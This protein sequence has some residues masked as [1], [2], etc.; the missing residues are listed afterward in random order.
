MKQFKQIYAF[1]IAAV[2]M[3]VFAMLSYLRLPTAY[4]ENEQRKLA[5]FPVLDQNFPDQ[6][7]SYANDQ[8]IL[9]D[10]FMEWKASLQYL[11]GQRN[12]NGIWVG[13]DDMLFQE[14]VSLSDTQLEN[15]TASLSAFQQKTKLKPVMMLIGDRTNLLPELLE[16]YM[17]TTN[18]LEDIE[19]LKNALPEFSF[20]DVNQ[21]LMHQKDAFYH[22]DHHYTSK[23][24]Y[25]CFQ[26]ISQEILGDVKPYE[27][28]ILPVSNT[29]SGTL[30]NQSGYH[31]KNDTVELYFPKACDV[32]YLVRINEQETT[33]IYDKSKADARNVYEIFLG[34]N[35][36][37]VEITTTV[38]NNK[39]LLLV[40]DSYANA[41]VP[42]LIPYYHKITLIDPRYYYDDIYHYIEEHAVNQVLFV[43]GTQTLFQDQSLSQL[44]QE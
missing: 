35:H 23:G 18:S 44:L 14:G 2:L 4:S 39:H 17:I 29:F 40:K 20:P 25:L 8:F 13:K 36:P 1:L 22:T 28:E 10:T 3:I 37:L 19:T 38:E 27:Y 6:L 31:R 43:Y 33:S 41:L 24:A 16:D 21:A 7:N 5:Q 30:A 42:F 11:S 9:R 26:A 15:L 12:L 32:Q 34:G